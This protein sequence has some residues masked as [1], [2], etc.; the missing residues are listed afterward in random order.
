M[1]YRLAV[2]APSL[3][4]TVG[5]RTASSI[6]TTTNPAQVIVPS[7]PSRIPKPSLVLPPLL[8]TNSAQILDPLFDQLK[9]RNAAFQVTK[10]ASMIRHVGTWALNSLL[11]RGYY[12]LTNSKK[13]NHVLIFV[14]TAATTVETVSGAIA[15]MAR[16]R[17][18]NLRLIASCLASI[19]MPHALF[20]TMANWPQVE[21][22]P[23]QWI[24]PAAMEKHVGKSKKTKILEHCRCRSLLWSFCQRMYLTSTLSCAP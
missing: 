24:K 23:L 9:A 1:A 12:S 6:V 19:R 3:A 10:L 22:A 21:H 7:T 17:A 4:T 2:A 13:S 5:A 11:L 15:L 20:S 18:M 8:W 14:C 16:G